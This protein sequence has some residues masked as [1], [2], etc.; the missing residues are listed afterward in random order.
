MPSERCRTEV[1]AMR[2]KVTATPSTAS[3]RTC[4]A[5][6]QSAMADRLLTTSPMPERRIAG[7]LRRT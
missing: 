4:S 7:S 6:R 3:P 1:A 2:A 5:S